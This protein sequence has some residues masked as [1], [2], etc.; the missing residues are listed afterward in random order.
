MVRT[1]V[2]DRSEDA[3]LV[4]AEIRKVREAFK[5]FKDLVW[6]SRES[7]MKKA[8]IQQVEQLKGM[9]AVRDHELGMRLSVLVS[10]L[11]ALWLSCF[12]AFLLF[13][14]DLF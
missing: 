8:D 1:Y 3:T 7:L 9:L 5:V 13:N 12:Y 6:E 11:L 2:N 10:L 4:I 14:I